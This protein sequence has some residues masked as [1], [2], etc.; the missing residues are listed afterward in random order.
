MTYMLRITGVSLLLGAL[1]LMAGIT[2]FFA[3]PGTVGPPAPALT[4][5]STVAKVILGDGTLGNGELQLK[6]NDAGI[7]VVSLAEPQIDARAYPFLHLAIE[8]SSSK[9]QVWISWNTGTKDKSNHSY[10]PHNK[11][12]TWLWLATNELQGWTDHISDLALVVVGQAGETVRIRDFGIY[13]TSPSRQLQAIF[14]DLAG[15]VPW[16]RAAMNSHTGVTPVSSFYPTTLIVAYLALSLLAYGVLLLVLRAKV[17]FS[18]QVVALI[19]LAC[20]ISLDVFWQNRLLH[21]VADTFH[22]FSGKS[23]QEKLTVGPDAQL[24][25]FVAQVIPLVQPTDSR[26]F[27]SSS[28]TYL[29]Q[30]GAYYLYPFNVFWPGPGGEFPADYLLHS[31]DFIMLINPTTLLF[32]ATKSVLA[33]STTTE[34]GVELLFSDTTG[35]M[36]RVK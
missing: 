19:F 15:Y 5:G 8:E 25:H 30:R 20:W 4:L 9:P 33:T 31:G 32:N 11:S 36:V 28:D 26:I 34:L 29:G 6:L 7:G 22:T 23:P 1:A 17:R 12:W 24:Y 27:V 10:V 3:P 16:N 2:L 21:Q 18:W 13:P 14:S 35:K